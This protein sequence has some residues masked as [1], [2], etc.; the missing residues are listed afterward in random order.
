[1]EV[2]LLERIEKLGLMGDTVSVKPGYARN[3]LLPRKKALRKT[4]ENLAYFEAQKAR[5]EAENLER[6]DE[7]ER[8][9][10]RMDGLSVSVI[11]AAGE[12]GQ[13]YGSVTARDIA[14]AVTEAGVSIGRGQVALDRALKALGLERVR[15][16]LHAE[17]AAHVTVN[18]ARSDEEAERQLALGRA[19]GAGDDFDDFDEEE[20]EDA[21]GA[22]PAPAPFP[23]P[24]P[25]E[26][27]QPSIEL[28]GET[29]P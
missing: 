19:V 28:D 4:R 6:R 16:Q 7:A 22:A 25:G 9:A 26:G 23:G 1:M 18:I 11:R 17:V 13:L 20:D 27:P 10:E 5:F 21:F 12:G 29:G 3:Y 14:A 15:V 8:I 2:I 24:A